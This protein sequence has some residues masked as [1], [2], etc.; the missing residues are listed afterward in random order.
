MDSFNKF[1]YDEACFKACMINCVSGKGA[2]GCQTA[3]QSVLKLFI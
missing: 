2:A 3:A 1:G